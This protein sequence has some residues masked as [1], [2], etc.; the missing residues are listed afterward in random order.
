M[1][2]WTVLAALDSTF[3]A[4]AVSSGV[5]TTPKERKR[6]WRQPDRRNTDVTAFNVVTMFLDFFDFDRVL[7]AEI[8]WL[9]TADA[10]VTTSVRFA[11]TNVSLAGPRSQSQ[12]ECQHDK[13]L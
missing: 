8:R 12:D 10:R 4:R 6:T 3:I 1:A 5:V 7:T 11:G 2:A 13:A 9:T